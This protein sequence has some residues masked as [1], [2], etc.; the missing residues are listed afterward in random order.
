MQKQVLHNQH[1]MDFALQHTGSFENSFPIALLN[2]KSVTD[3]LGAGEILG[4]PEKIIKDDVLLNYYTQKQVEPATAITQSQIDELEANGIG[5]MII[6][7]TF[8]VS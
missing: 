1:L 5:Y 6:E 4:I 8:I 3:S 7:E 2:G